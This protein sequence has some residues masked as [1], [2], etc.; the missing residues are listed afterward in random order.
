MKVT[1]TKKAIEL[2]YANS[3]LWLNQNNGSES[4]FLFALRKIR[5]KVKSIYEDYVEK[6]QELRLDHASAD[7]KGNISMQGQHIDFKPEKLK[8]LQKKIKLVN[9]EVVEIEPHYAILTEDEKKK[10]P[11]A[12]REIFLNFVLEDKDE[13]PSEEQ[14]QEEKSN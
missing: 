7:D 12:F 2:F 10:L 5:K 3:E 4:K 8:E 13:E 14:K 11:V 1:V 9:S 6:I